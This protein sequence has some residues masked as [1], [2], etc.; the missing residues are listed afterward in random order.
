MQIAATGVVSHDLS[1]WYLSLRRPPALATPALF[2]RIWAAVGFTQGIAAWL[3]WRQVDPWRLS[4][5]PALRLWAWQIAL[6]ALWA[7]VFFRL[8]APGLALIVAVML[9]VVSAAT[10][11][12]F[13]RR[14][15]VAG[16]LLLP[17]LV[18]L[19]YA[20]YLNFGFWWLNLLPG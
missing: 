11:R 10:L 6:L 4:P 3:I 9:A 19:C 13:W 1:H 16:A 12:A 20:A 5:R 2:G 15:R 7:P 17:P 18:W 8:H 14:H